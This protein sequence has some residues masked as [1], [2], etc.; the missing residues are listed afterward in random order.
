MIAAIVAAES[1]L[2][3]KHLIAEGIAVR[4]TKIEKPNPAISVFNSHSA[5]PDAVRLNYDLNKVIADDETGGKGSAALPYRREAWQFILAGGGVY[6][7]LDFAFTCKHPDGGAKL[8]SEP[9][10]GGAEIRAQLK[11]LKEFIERFDFVR[12]KPDPGIVKGGRITP[13]AGKR[14]IDLDTAVNVL[15]DRGRAYAI[16]I[17]RGTQ[18]QLI[19]EVPAGKYTAEWIDTTT[20]LVVKAE[21]MEHLGGNMQWTSPVYEE[22][23]ALRLI[24]KEL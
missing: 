16:Y 23:I 22:D 19:L 15:A 1:T 7:H 3:H 13:P 5:T 21:A 11:V 18:A 10:G 24:V 6:S 4:S 2:P 8:T 9:G 17:G 12:M 14:P 20:G